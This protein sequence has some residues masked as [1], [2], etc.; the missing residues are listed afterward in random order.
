MQRY[1]T[2]R[3]AVNYKRSTRRI[4]IWMPL[5]LDFPSISATDTR[6]AEAARVTNSTECCTVENIL[7]LVK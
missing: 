6:T 2:P 4:C 5:A 7:C 1:L 3:I